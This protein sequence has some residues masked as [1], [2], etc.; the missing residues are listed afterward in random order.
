MNE[1]NFEFIWGLRAHDLP[2]KGE[3]S[4]D[5]I[6]D[7]EI[8]KTGDIYRLEIETIW[9]ETDDGG[10]TPDIANHLKY[11]LDEFTKFMKANGF[12]T[13]YTYKIDNAPE[14]SMSALSIEELYINFK[15]FV[16]GVCSL[17]N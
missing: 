6:N 8:I 5:T 9:W 13:D 1:R 2:Q 12:N 3:A 11:M 15:I 10:F 14:L 17:Y 16:N 7:I 4:E